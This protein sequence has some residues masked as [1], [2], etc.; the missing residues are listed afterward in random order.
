MAKAQD[1]V[2]LVETKGYVPAVEAGDAMVK[3]ANVEI[4]GRESIGG[5]YVTVAISGDVG[6]VKAAIDAGATAA[7]K[8]GELVSA[9]L[10]PRPHEDVGKV[11]PAAAARTT[12]KR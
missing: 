1:A 8:T 3:A 4:V 6:A 2:G 7:K 9:H 12:A 11:L 5:G 10:I